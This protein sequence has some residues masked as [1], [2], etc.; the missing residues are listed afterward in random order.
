MNHRL[1]RRSFLQGIG[2]LAAASA[3]SARVPFGNVGAAAE[4]R[5]AYAAITWHG[6]DAQAITD[7]SAVGYRGIQLRFNAVQSYGSQP[8][9][10]RDLLNQHHLELVALSSGDVSGAADKR[11]DEI[12]RHARNAEFVRDVGGHYLQLTDSAMPKGRK[13][14]ADDYR[15]LGQTM[16]EIGK[17][18]ADVGVSVG[19]HNHMGGLG[20]AP[21]DVERILNEAD[22]RYVKLLLDIAHYAQGGGDPARAVRQYRDRLLFFHI[23]DVEAIAPK[24]PTDAARAYRFVELGQGRVNLPEVFAAI[25]AIKFKGWAVVELDDVTDPARSPKESAIISKRYLEEKLKLKV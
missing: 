20:E 4:I 1:S 11:A 22:S 15:Q 25:N 10:L 19:Y 21:D 13:P 8:Q 5:F 3:A 12:A 24:S 17:R 18:A 16:T 2:A 23:K 7:I 9:A 14:I 6:N